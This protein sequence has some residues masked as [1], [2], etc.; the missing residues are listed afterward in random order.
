[1]INRERLNKITNI[2]SDS[3]IADAEFLLA[4]ISELEQEL[5]RVLDERNF[6]R[7]QLKE[8]INMKNEKL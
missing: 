5:N 3:G 8:F 4:C 1:M 2:F 6:L 7:E